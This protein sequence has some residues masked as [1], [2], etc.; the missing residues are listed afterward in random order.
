MPVKNLLILP[1]IG[2][3]AEA[4][5]AEPSLKKKPNVKE[6]GCEAEQREAVGPLYLKVPLALLWRW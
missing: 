1:D 5:N 3:L 4:S 6:K 2:D